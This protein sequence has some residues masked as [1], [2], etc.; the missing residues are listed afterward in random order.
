MKNILKITLL[1][2]LAVSCKKDPTF[3]ENTYKLGGGV[4]ILNEG[5]YRGGNGSLSFYSYDSLKM[6]NDLFATKNNRP[7]GDVPNSMVIR[8]DNGYIVVN[9]SNKIEVI[10]PV[11]LISKTTITGMKS[12]RILAPVNSTYAYVSSLYSDSITII[13]MTKNSISG[14]INIRRTSEAI[15]AGNNKAYVANWAGGNEI[16]VIN[17]LQNKVID[18]IKVGNE[19]ESMVLDRNFDLWVLCSGTYAGE[20]FAKLVQINI[21]TDKVIK[22]YT[23]PTKEASPSCLRIDALGHTLYYLDNGVKS[24]EINLGRLPASSLIADPNSSFYKIGI[25]PSNGDIFVTDAVDYS[26]QGW[27]LIYT[28]EGSIITKEKADIIPAA[29]CFK[30]KVN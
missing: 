27:V 18:S 14:Y 12:P 20:D 28:S 6:Y 11:T 8:E 22:E 4:F 23:F 25:N 2:L 16:I 19:P 30:L 17:T 24:M 29:M 21:L 5:N 13:D 9:N 1:L 7:L 3:H 26:S 10:D 15:L